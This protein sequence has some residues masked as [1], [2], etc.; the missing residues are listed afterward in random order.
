MNGPILAHRDGAVQVLSFNNPAARNA[1]TPEVYK[2][3][4]AALDEAQR[5]AGVAAIVLTGVGGPFCAGGDLNRLAQRRA[6][7][8]PERR[9]GIEGLHDMIR[10][11]RD[12]SKPVIAA[13]EG[14]AAGAGLSIALA[15][16]ML[17]TAPNASFSVA[18]VKVG[19][20]PDGGVT[21]L[22]SGFV[23]RQLLTEFCLT[24]RPVTGERMHALGVVNRLVERGN[25]LAEAI[26]MAQSL[27][28]GPER[29]IARIKILCRH[30]GENTL[31]AQLD[32]EARY[33]TESLGDD[34]A[35]E[36]ISA[37]FEKRPPDFST[38]RRTPTV[39]S[40]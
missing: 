23:S 16:D 27:A 15:C 17:L 40:Q 32:L 35:A 2:A 31:E 8:P 38:L 3:L 33:M 6:M 36:G 25:V 28:S 30:A 21:A 20:S 39:H 10:A 29:A 22:L 34:E 4:P 7:T 5:D 14:A 11:I 24:G 37:F 19:L 1:L 13:V 18:Y 9:A 12:C 26:A